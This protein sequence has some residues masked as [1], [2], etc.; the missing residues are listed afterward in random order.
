MRNKIV[1]HLYL[2]HDCSQKDDEFERSWSP[3]NFMIYDPLFFDMVEEALQGWA[4]EHEMRHE[5]VYELIME[6]VIDRDRVGAVTGEYF[7]LIH[8]E[9]EIVQ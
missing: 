6:H 3:I 7:T 8:S 5:W 1:A 2:P 4:S 9:V